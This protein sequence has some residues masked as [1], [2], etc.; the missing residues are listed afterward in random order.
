MI[1]SIVLFLSLLV[2]ANAM[3]EEMLPIW[4]NSQGA[5]VQIGVRDKFGALG[6]YVVKFVVKDGNGE[7]FTMEKEVTS[8]NWGYVSFPS[9]FEVYSNPGDYTWK[10]YVG[11]EEVGEGSFIYSTVE[12]FADQVRV[13]RRGDEGQ[14]YSS[15]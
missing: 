3:A 7:E 6:N 10:A 4:Q 2:G 5:N 11:E 9:D 15:M 12:T 1:K 14:R 8:D 13:I